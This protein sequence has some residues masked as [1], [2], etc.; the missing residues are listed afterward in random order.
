MAW[1]A[2]QIAVIAAGCAY[3]AAAP[4]LVRGAGVAFIFRGECVVVG[5][6]A[7]KRRRTTKYISPTD[8]R[9]DLAGELPLDKGDVNAAFP[10]E[11]DAR[12]AEPMSQ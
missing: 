11:T 4:E 5:N 1:E 12:H 10:E 2:P 8:G 7:E 9:L 3:R 6:S